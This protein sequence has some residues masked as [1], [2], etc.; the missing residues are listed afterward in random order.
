[1]GK[2]DGLPRA[3]A[4]RQPLK[5]RDGREAG[6]LRVCVPAPHLP[7]TLGVRAVGPVSPQ[8]RM[9]CG[10]RLTWARQ[11]VCHLLMPNSGL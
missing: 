11:T 5:R 9:R 4:E 1:M 2:A 7:L 6:V 10:C 8:L 3:H